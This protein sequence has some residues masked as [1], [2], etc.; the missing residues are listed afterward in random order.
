MSL[1]VKLHMKKIVLVVMSLLMFAGEAE[2][3]TKTTKKPTARPVKKATNAGGSQI[4]FAIGQMK[5]GQY[6]AASNTL[7]ALSRRSEYAKD[8]AQIKYLMGLAMIEIGLDQVA[9]F[10]FVDVIRSGENRFVR[11]ALEKLLITT[12]KLGDETLLNYAIQRIDVNKLPQQYKDVLY[13]RLGE[14]KQKGKQY[15][16]AAQLYGNVAQTSRYYLNST[17]NMALAQAEAGQ[18]D[19]A[20]DSF[21]RLLSARAS[22]D[23][24]DTNK[25]AAMMGMARIYYQKQEWS[26]AIEAYSMIPRDHFMWHDAIFEQSWAMLRAARFR[27]ALSNFQSLHSSFYDDFYIPETLLLRSIVYLY[28]CKYDE[29][30][31][32]LTLFDKQY[33]AVSKNIDNFLK[34]SS[35]LAYYNEVEK[36]YLDK[37]RDGV[38]SKTRLSY[39]AAKQISNEGDV[40]RSLAYIK[41]IVAERKKIENDARIRSL[42]VGAYSLKLLANR[43]KSAKERTGD[44]TKAHLQNMSNELADL[45]EQSALIRYEMINGKKETLKK[46]LAEKDVD[47]KEI[48]EDK[49]RSF[50]AQ[51]GYEYYP[52]QGE[53]WLDEVGNYHYLGKQSCE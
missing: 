4:N 31:K 26:K 32:V 19:L 40:R 43:I 21:K 50:Y 10:Q 38:K 16:E 5:N 27:S 15:S 12:D 20:M 14:I 22:A 2:A 7:L 18:T 46:R 13:F 36:A 28:I 6:L 3:Q 45:K 52:F 37:F 24:R 23:V 48:N 1:N 30:D 49:D 44:L 47:D 25:I 17:Y 51:N 42:P 8:K 29:M 11:S 53:F 39:V 35:A 34:N 9:A 33:G 41:K